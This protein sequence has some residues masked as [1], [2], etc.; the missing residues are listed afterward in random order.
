LSGAT[1]RSRRKS[2]GLDSRPRPSARAAGAADLLNLGCGTHRHPAWRN[3]DLLPGA[4]DVEQHDLR[5][6]LPFQDASFDAVYH[7]H[8]LEHLTPDDGERLLQEC[9]RV[10]RPGGILRIVVPDLEAIARAYIAAVD[11][12]RAGDQGASAD[13]EWLC[14][15]LFDQMVRSRPGGRM[16]N[17][18]RNPDL[19][20]ASFVRS[21][22]GV[23]VEAAHGAATYA[24]PIPLWRRL[25]ERSPGA[26]MRAIRY[27]AATLMVRLLAGE[28]GSAAFRE[29]LF[30]ASGEVH[31]WMYDE[32]SL[33]LL[34][35]RSGLQSV[36]FCGA[37]ESGIPGFATFGLDV[38]AGSVRKPDSL[39]CEGV[40]PE[41][42][43]DT[44]ASSASARS[45]P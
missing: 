23:E 37:D 1:P 8:V 36:T 16:G 21:R 22:M 15:E 18:M 2:G 3:L 34:L 10:L 11:R 27:R 31:R 20:N 32:V 14:H 29:G 42:D 4:S 25:A 39:Y 30:R 43:M 7:S 41:P 17:A 33:G 45:T 9:V 38:V 24:Q 13:R 5:R 26:W 19:P 12:L 35:R 44:V 6:P 28:E 40:K